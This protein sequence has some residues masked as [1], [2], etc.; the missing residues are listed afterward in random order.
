[1]G[2]HPKV[3]TVLGIVFLAIGALS[4]LTVAQGWYLSHSVLWRAGL[5]GLLDILIA[6]AFFD[7]QRWL[8]P[9]LGLNA[10]GQATLLAVHAYYSTALG[11][12]FFFA[13]FG[14]TLA[15]ALFWYVHRNRD[16]L[17]H[18]N[19]SYVLGGLFVCTWGVSFWYLLSNFL[20]IK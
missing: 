14:T 7:R 9:A 20:P 13:V 4:F 15:I 5:F 19:A 17:K 3:F 18:T 8:E 16:M 1:M 12:Q 11:G 10:A 2:I 6:Y